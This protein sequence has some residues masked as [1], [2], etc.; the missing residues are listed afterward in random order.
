M[1]N[2]SK[3]VSSRIAALMLTASAIAP[4]CV[5]NLYHALVTSVGHAQVPLITD[6]GGF[7]RFGMLEG[8]KLKVGSRTFECAGPTG[9]IS[10]QPQASR[11]SHSTVSP[12][13]GSH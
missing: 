10:C 2:K 4:I 8:L 1:K 9:A 7:D 13:T 3:P 5:L 12:E 6:L 11:P